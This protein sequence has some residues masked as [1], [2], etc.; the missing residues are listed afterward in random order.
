M[1]ARSAGELTKERGRLVVARLPPGRHPAGEHAGS[2]TG[3]AWTVINAHERDPAVYMR[4]MN[5][6]IEATAAGGFLPR[7]ST[8]IGFRSKNSARARHDARTGR[9]V[10]IKALGDLP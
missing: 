7:G 2:G 9:K 1:A 10:F 8:P 5:E 3:A 6:A 4:G